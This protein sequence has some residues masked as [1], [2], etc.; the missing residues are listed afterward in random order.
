MGTADR[1]LPGGLWPMR[2]GGYVG[3]SQ[4]EQQIEASKRT[5]SGRATFVGKSGP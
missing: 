3:A 2:A 4:R 1:Y 5:A